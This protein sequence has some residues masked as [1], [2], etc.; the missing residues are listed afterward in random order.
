MCRGELFSRIQGLLLL[1]GGGTE[2][3]NTPDRLPKPSWERMLFAAALGTEEQ[4]LLASFIDDTHWCLLTSKRLI[5]RNA[6]TSGSLRWSEIQEFDEGSQ[7]VTVGD[8]WG[9]R[10]PLPA[11]PGRG[12]MLL[13]TALLELWPGVTAKAA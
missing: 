4:G 10:M 9:D 7:E 2:R 3:T 1:Q 13:Q 5:W 8:G 12:R 6:P 11:E